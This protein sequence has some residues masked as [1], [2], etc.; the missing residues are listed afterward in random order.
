MPESVLNELLVD[1]FNDILNIQQQVLQSKGLKNLSITEV[2]TIEKIGKKSKRTMSQVASELGIT[3]GTLSTSINHLVKKGYVERAR[4]EEDRRIVYLKL[5]K[6]GI[7]AKRIHETFHKEMVQEAII[8]L[9]K[10]ERE[11]LIKSMR[12]L[13]TFF[14]N[15]QSK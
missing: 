2:H 5:T 6:K 9:S 10:E 11:V 7:D 1:T 14:K 4:S 15:K 3:I 12:K 13:N 8:E